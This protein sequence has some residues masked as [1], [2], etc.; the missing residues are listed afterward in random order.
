MD[1]NL[2][3]QADV[4]NSTTLQVFVHYSRLRFGG[5]SRL[6]K[7]LVRKRSSKFMIAV[8]SLKLRA[9]PLSLNEF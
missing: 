1:M 2:E 8:H 6:L 4:E 7:R 5:S 9:P 3:T